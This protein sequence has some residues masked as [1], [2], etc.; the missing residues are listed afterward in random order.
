MMAQNE[1]YGNQAKLFSCFP[2]GNTRGAKVEV[3]MVREGKLYLNRPLQHLIPLE[4]NS[5]DTD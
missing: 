5:R 4:V 2:D 3:S 1:H